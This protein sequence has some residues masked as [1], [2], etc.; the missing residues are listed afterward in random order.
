MV[1]ARLCPTDYHR[2]HFPVDCFATHPKE[3]NGYLYSVNP[4][5]VRKNI[6]IFSENKR[7]I[8]FLETENYSLDVCV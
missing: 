6:K 3:I 4:L 7:V 1:I 2:F 5:A 8:T